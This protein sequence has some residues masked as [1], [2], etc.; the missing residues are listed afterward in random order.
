M[1]VVFI[2]L[3]SSEVKK[4]QMNTRRTKLIFVVC[5][6][7]A[8]HCHWIPGGPSWFSSFAIQ[9][10]LIVICSL[11]HIELSLQE[12]QKKA[13]KSDK[14][15]QGKHLQTGVINSTYTGN[16]NLCLWQFLI[17]GTLALLSW[18]IKL[19]SIALLI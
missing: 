3:R 1:Q 6:S 19:K 4:I 13:S 8:A 10:L 2:L 11:Q 16:H 17:S 5:H 18:E 9:L 12:Q 15:K 7:T 14:F